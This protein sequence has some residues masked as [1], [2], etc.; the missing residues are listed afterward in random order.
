MPA[1]RFHRVHASTAAAAALCDPALSSIHLVMLKIGS[2]EQRVLPN[3]PSQVVLGVAL[4]NGEKV[5]A[6]P[7]EWILLRRRGFLLGTAVVVIAMSAIACDLG[8]IANAIAAGALVI[9]AFSISRAR[10]I[11][12]K[13]F[14]INEGWGNLEETFDT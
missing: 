4:K 9:G 1:Q 14:W 12:T 10:S 6:V 13:P 8:V 7:E 2:P 3:R 11:H 5:M